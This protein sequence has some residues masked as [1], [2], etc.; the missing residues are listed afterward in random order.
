MTDIV[1]AVVMIEYD[2]GARAGWMFTNVQSAAA[3]HQ[4][5]PG[6][7][8]FSMVGHA[9]AIREPAPIERRFTEAIDTLAPPR[10]EP[11]E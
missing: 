6:P 8:R 2:D 1:K 7:A 11:P 4:G 5:L 9:E 10:Q 3:T